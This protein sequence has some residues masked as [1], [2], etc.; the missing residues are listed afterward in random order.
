MV[1][2]HARDEVLSFRVGG[3]EVVLHLNVCAVFSRFIAGVAS[4]FFN[5][6]ATYFLNFFIIV[7]KRMRVGNERI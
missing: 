7:C 1:G 6:L 2:V 3:A 4:T 5:A